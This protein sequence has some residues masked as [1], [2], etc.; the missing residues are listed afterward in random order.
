MASF[1]NKTPKCFPPSVILALQTVTSLVTMTPPN[2]QCPFQ[3][4][5][6]GDPIPII[7]TDINTDT[8]TNT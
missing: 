4:L 6:M 5:V 3:S 8:D 1:D 2:Q 7:N